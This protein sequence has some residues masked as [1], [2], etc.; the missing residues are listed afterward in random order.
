[1]YGSLVLVLTCALHVSKARLRPKP[2]DSAKAP[3]HS[4]KGKLPQQQDGRD[5]EPQEQEDDVHEDMHD[6]T[7]VTHEKGLYSATA[8]ENTPGA[9][10]SHC[11][12]RLLREI[13]SDR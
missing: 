6:H 10:K 5:H 2:E 1:M 3:K 8:F 9:S 11:N 7:N 4:Q 12:L 13:L